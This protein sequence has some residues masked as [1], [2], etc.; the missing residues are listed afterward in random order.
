MDENKN[1][2]HDRWNVASLKEYFD[3]AMY[4]LDEKLMTIIKKDEEAVKVANIAMDHRLDGMNKIKEQLN[5]QAKE[6]LKT[7]VFEAKHDL[8]SSRL[9]QLQKIVW[10]G[11]GIWLVIQG[12]IVVVLVA[13][14]KK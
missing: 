13:V 14:F 11:L 12:I 8:L 2:N 3:F 9:E 7:E 5:D 4:T 6:F 1:S 10:I